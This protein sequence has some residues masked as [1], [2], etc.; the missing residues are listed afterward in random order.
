MG[1]TNFQNTT[2]KERLPVTSSE[3]GDIGETGFK[4]G[5]FV[6]TQS[7]MRNITSKQRGGGEAVILVDA[8]A[9]GRGPK[10]CLLGEH[11][12]G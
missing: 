2:C 7:F 8:A 10:P 12:R 3:E 6:A 4:I 1:C 5:F 11:R 9:L